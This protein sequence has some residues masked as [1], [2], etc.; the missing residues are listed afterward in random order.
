MVTPFTEDNRIDFAA[1]EALVD[2]VIAGGADNLVA[3]GTTAETPTLSMAER[4]DV[5]ACIKGKN[6]GRLPLVAGIGGNNT[7][8][9]VS[10]VEQFDFRG[11]DAFLSVTPFYNKPTQRGMYE[12]YKAVAGATDRPLILYN[13]PGRTGVNLLPETTLKLA[14]EVKNVVAVKEACGN[15]SQV[16]YILRDRPD[17][18]MVLSGDDNM[19]LPMIALGADGVISVAANAFPAR[20][21][22]MIHTALD[23]N[24]AEAAHMH[25]SMM[26]PVDALFAEG[27]PTGIKAALHQKG[28]IQNILRLPLVPASDVLYTRIEQL[29]TRYGLM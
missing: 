11:V 27:N 17:G 5:L 7:A 13:V 12:H 21:A 6:A 26:E 24:I 3:L 23:G 10:Q 20:F 9:I 1:L 18:F 22:R 4:K 25:L 8:D 15:L 14:H 2:Y 29:M 16:G 19:A 28:L